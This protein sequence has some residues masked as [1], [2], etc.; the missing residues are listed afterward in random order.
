VSHADEA[1]LGFMG[2]E[3]HVP[4]IEVLADYT[5]TEVAALLDAVP[6]APR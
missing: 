5:G 2:C 6:T 1:A 3:D 4:D